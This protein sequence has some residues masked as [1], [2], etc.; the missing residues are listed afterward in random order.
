MGAPRIASGGQPF[1]CFESPGDLVTFDDAPVL[2]WLSSSILY[3]RHFW[4][5][6][7]LVTIA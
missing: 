6:P 3:P 2:M 5:A 1:E 7:V 4:Q